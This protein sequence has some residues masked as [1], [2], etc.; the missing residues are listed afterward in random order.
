MTPVERVRFIPADKLATEQV[1]YSIA[2]K[3]TP[4]IN[5]APKCV[6]HNMRND[7]T[8]DA[9]NKVC[10]NGL[11]TTTT[12]NRRCDAGNYNDN[13]GRCEAPAVVA[14]DEPTLD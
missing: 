4:A 2:S 6:F 13:T 14:Y 1:G 8:W 11:G 10:K 12:V 9:S 5:E 7:W 3:T